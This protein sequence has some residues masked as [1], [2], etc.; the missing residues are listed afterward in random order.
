VPTKIGNTTLAVV[1]TQSV[2]DKGPCEGD[3]GVWWGPGYT[4]TSVIGPPFGQPASTGYRSCWQVNQ[5]QYKSGLPLTTIAAEITMAVRN[6]TYKLVRNQTQTYVP[7]TDSGLAVTADEFY[8]IDQ[9]IP[10]P[11]IDKAD[12]NLM[13]SMPTWSSV[14]L[15]NY[16]SLLASLNNII[17]SQPPCNGDA[18]LDGVVDSQDLSIWQRLL[19]WALS[20]IADFNLDG[21]TNNSDAE[22]IRGN[23]GTCVKATTIY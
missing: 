8:Q 14:V 4:D 22:I 17:A 1:C 6:D 2:F 13:P 9:A 20:S 5:A 10:T 7:S 18:N 12:L 15:Q 11:K 23:Q 16:N 19:N 21:L 3:A